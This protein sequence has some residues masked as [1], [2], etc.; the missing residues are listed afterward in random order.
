LRTKPKENFAC[1]R[2][3]L[4]VAAPD[5]TKLESRD[6]AEVRR[7]LACYVSAYGAPGSASHAALRKSQRQ[8]AERPLHHLVAAVLAERLASQPQDEGVLDLG[9]LIGAP[10][11]ACAGPS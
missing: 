10:S 1:L 2:R 9:S 3:L 8:E 4:G 7:V 5:P 6:V 11:G